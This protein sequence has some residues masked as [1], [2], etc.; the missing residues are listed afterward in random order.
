MLKS[1]HI[2]TF[3][4]VLHTSSFADAGKELGYTASAVSQQMLALEKSMGITLFER[5]PQGIKPTAAANTLATQTKSAVAAMARLEQQAASIASGGAGTLWLASFATAGEKL[6]PHAI[7]DLLSNRPAIEVL[8]DE[9][10]PDVLLPRLL[11]G[12]MN[13]VLAYEYSAV[14][15][16]WPD[17]LVRHLILREDLI[18]LIPSRLTDKSFDARTGLASLAKERWIA[19][20]VGTAGAASLNYVCAANGFSP[21]VAFRSNNYA[22]ITGMVASGLGVAIVPAL[23]YDPTPNVVAR[24]FDA[25]FS[26]RTVY[27][28][29]NPEDEHLLLATVISSLK[30]A[31]KRIDTSQLEKIGE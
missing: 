24:R 1:S 22:T 5:R 28:L 15:R 23:G 29:H 2:K 13:L 27:A 12:E 14:P 26:S 4:V 11:E 3:L 8:L 20:D 31:A 10:E 16:R 25:K 9:G 18:L 30:G 21:Q 17:E 19:T 6:V 7:V